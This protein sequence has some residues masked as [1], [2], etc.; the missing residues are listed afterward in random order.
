MGTATRWMLI[1][2][3]ALAGCAGLT[4]HDGKEELKGLPFYVKVPVATQ[5]TLRATSELSIQLKVSEFIESD[6]KQVTLRSQG[7]LGS[8]PV[9]VPDTPATRKL[10]DDLIAAIPDDR[11]ATYERTI[12]DISDRIEK[13]LVPKAS[14]RITVADCT[15]AA[16]VLSNS[17]SI[18][19]V[20]DP[21]RHYITT[22][23]P[24]MGSASSTFKLASDGTL[25]EA[26][27]QVTEDTTKTI[28]G[29]LPI[30]AKLTKQWGLGPEEPAKESADAE[31]AFKS[32]RFEPPPP[33]KPAP[34]PTPL[35][36]RINVEVTL[37]SIKT[38]YTLRKSHH[39]G[40]DPTL[41]TYLGL[42]ANGAPLDMCKALRGEDGTQLVSVVT[43]SEQSDSKKADAAAKAW[44]IQG[45]V[46]PPKPDGDGG[47][48]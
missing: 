12:R 20:A 1:T 43:A 8:G 41:N 25:T 36:K 5:D 19:M 28:L 37:T 9:Q 11:K 31:F 2:P 42:K 27:S 45:S 16:D 18:T 39:F 32:F 34:K 7:V 17:W 35:A 44:Q 10:I 29:L 15:R 14:G 24:V 21:K 48:K 40:D 4:V 3:V 13:D 38:V 22:K 23:I 47:G 6:A 46:T 30:T 26:A 33:G